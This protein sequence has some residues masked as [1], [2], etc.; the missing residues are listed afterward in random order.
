M[1]EQAIT[2]TEGKHILDNLSVLNQNMDKIT[3]RVVDPILL[4]HWRSYTQ[5]N[6]K[7]YPPVPPASTYQRTKELFRSWDVL[8]DRRAATVTTAAGVTS[9]V[10]YAEWVVGEGQRDFH[11][12]AGWVKLPD[13]EEPLLK[14]SAPIAARGYESEVFRFL[15]KRGLI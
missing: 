9:N 15:T 5:Q 12:A 2:I 10:D 8:S 11:A 4:K 6:L 1:A 3:G 13:H 7:P 14:S